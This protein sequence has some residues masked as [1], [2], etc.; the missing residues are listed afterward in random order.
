[1][2][3][4][5][6][7]ATL[8]TLSLSTADV[9]LS[10]RP[11]T[12]RISGRLGN[13]AL[14]ND[15][16]SYSILEEFNQ[17]MSIEGQNFADFSYQTFDPDEDN[18][19]GVRSSIHLNAA[20]IKFQ[21]VEQPL[22]DILLFISKLAKLKGL[23]DA[24]TQV[25]VQKASELEKTEFQIS[26]KTPIVVFPSSPSLSSDSLVLQLGQIGACTGESVDRISASLHG[27]QL[28]S[29]LYRDGRKSTLKIIDD[30]DVVADI[31]QRDRV[32]G[33]QESDLPDI[34]VCDCIA[35]LWSLTKFA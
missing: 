1:V 35:V 9:A 17:L 11:K 23:Y 29:N 12:L 28:V 15:N 5:D 34:Q 14:A 4:T 6:E 22:H 18:Y 27:I 32:S 20:S 21:F 3:L 16:T 10:I 2:I 26:V 24:A 25:A 8:A 19:T 31:L 7:R 30:I 33:K 13:L